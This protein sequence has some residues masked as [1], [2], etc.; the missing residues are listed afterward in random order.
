MTEYK[1]IF[2][3]AYW[4]L[5]LLGGVHCFGVAL[6]IRIFHQTPSASHKSLAGVFTLIGFYFLTGIFTKE[7]SI[8]YFLWKYFGFVLK[9]ELKP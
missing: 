6:Y 8:S 9:F 1:D 4:W 5:S 2:I 7:S 3:Q